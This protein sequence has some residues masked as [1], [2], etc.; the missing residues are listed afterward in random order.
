MR[1]IYLFLLIKIFIFAAVVD[2][3]HDIDISDK[4]LNDDSCKI[5][6]L[7]FLR[8]YSGYF[9]FNDHSLVESIVTSGFDSKIS[10]KIDEN[11]TPVS[12]SGLCLSCHDGVSAINVLHKT[13]ISIN[14]KDSHPVY[15]EYIEGKSGLRKKSTKIYG[16][17]NASL[18]NDLLA[19]GKVVCI[20]CHSAH[21]KTNSNYL[22]HSNTDSKLC[23]TCHDK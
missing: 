7:S 4:D 12:S 23:Y 2:N 17:N 18:I 20:S 10:E 21:N 19:N 3:P 5:C 6:H 14:L 13:S 16:W 1:N 11:Y 22:R 15:I 8:E 9:A